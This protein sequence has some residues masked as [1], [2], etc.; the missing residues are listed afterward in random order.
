M[1]SQMDPGFRLPRWRDAM[2]T[3]NAFSTG[4]ESTQ[5]HTSFTYLWLETVL[6]LI[7]SIVFIY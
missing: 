7:G 6:A 4:Y 3:T 5:M 1:A 2:Q